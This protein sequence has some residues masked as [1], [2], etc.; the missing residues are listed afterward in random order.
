MAAAFKKTEQVEQCICI[1]FCIKL[2]HSST[3]TIQVTHKAT[4]MGNWWL[5]VSSWQCAHWCIQ[6]HAEVLGKHQ[7]THLTQLPYNPDLV[8]CDSWL[9]PK[10]KSPLKGKRLQTVEIQ[11]NMT[12]QLMVLGENCVRSQG[13]CFEGIEVSM[14]Y[15]QCFLYLVSSSIN[16]SIF[17]ITW[18]DTFWTD[19]IYFKHS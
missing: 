15:V 10:L 13:A 18:L 8:P 1:I 11:E 17:H 4:T 19:L 3:E 6:S 9:F 2:G 16:V 12:M 5:A 14:S 7:I